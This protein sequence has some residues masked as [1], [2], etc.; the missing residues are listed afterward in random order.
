MGPLSPTQR[1][2][3][4]WNDQRTVMNGMAWV[5]QSGSARR[6]MLEW[7]GQWQ[8]VYDRFVRSRHDGTFDQIANILKERWHGECLIEWYVWCVDRISVRAAK[9]AAGARRVSK[10]GPDPIR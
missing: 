6:E 2:G 4:K 5:L 10:N 1:R 7:Y 8:T 3:G 9:P